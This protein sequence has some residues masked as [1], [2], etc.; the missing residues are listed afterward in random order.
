MLENFQGDSWGSIPPLRMPSLLPHDLCHGRSASRWLPAVIKF[1]LSYS[2]SSL[3]M[4]YAGSRQTL[5]SQ[6]L[7]SVS[8]QQKFVFRL[9]AEH[10]LK[11]CSG[12]R[13]HEN[14]SYPDVEEADVRRE[15]RKGPGDGRLL[16]SPGAAI[17]PWLLA[18]L[19]LGASGGNCISPTGRAGPPGVCWKRLSWAQALSHSILITAPWSRPVTTP[20]LRMRILNPRDVWLRKQED[21]KYKEQQTPSFARL[22][23]PSLG[24]AWEALD[25]W[26]TALWRP[27]PPAHRS[28]FLPWD[29]P[30]HPT[31]L[32]GS[33]RTCPAINLPSATLNQETIFPWGVCKPNCNHIK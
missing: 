15:G 9:G 3:N 28:F 4:Q 6:E 5:S 18:R 12:K 33:L 11:L 10:S 17:G 29:A 8:L 25:P 30:S 14:L 20:V 19:L 7:M 21:G 24:K 31:Q 16:P 2:R 22:W 13:D 26:G 23:W 32:S 1:Q 27:R